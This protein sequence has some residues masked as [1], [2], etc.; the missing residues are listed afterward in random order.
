MN[1]N[2]TNPQ[3]PATT[4]IGQPINPHAQAFIADV[5]DALAAA[6]KPALPV[7]TSFRNDALPS[8]PT[9]GDAPPVPQPGRPP[10]SEAATNISGVMIASSVPILAL[11]VA[12]SGVMYFSGQADP[13]VIGLICATPIGLTI[14]ILALSR[15]VKRA[16]QTVEAAPAEQHHHYSGTVI[17]DHRTTTTH[18]RG[19]W[20]KTRN[21]LPR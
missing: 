9:I 3:Q 19:V 7:P 11:G 6:T 15:L 2:L 1:V 8:T 14:P 4:Q 10:M 17:Q 18:T 20:A 12:A 13:T 16:K 5:E 21:Q